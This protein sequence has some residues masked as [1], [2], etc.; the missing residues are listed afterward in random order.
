MGLGLDEVLFVPNQIPPHRR[1]EPALAPARD[2]YVMVCLALAGNPAFKAGAMELDR[3]EV[4]Y[5]VQTVARL[6]ADH[7]QDRFTF[8][9]G[10]DSLSKDP[11]YKLDEL[12]GMLERFVV[13]TRRGYPLSTLEARLDVYAL[14]NRSKVVTMP[15]PEVEVSATEIRRRVSQGQPIT[16]LVPAAVEDYVLKMGLYR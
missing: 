13:V 8:I 4:S 11:W 7:P 9:T 16:Y 12:I 10:A 5:T 2:R 15:I 14:R 6:C 3:D 1:N